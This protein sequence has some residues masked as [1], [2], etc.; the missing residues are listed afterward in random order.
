MG[1]EIARQNRVCLLDF[2][3]HLPRNAP[4]DSETTISNRLSI[5]YTQLKAQ[6]KNSIKPSRPINL[7]FL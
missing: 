2:C 3:Q 5:V 4:M 7:I 6:S 1:S